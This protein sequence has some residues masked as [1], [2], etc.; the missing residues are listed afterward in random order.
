MP[1]THVNH[2]GIETSQGVHFPMT[3]GYK[4]LH[5]FVTVDALLGKDKPSVGVSYLDRFAPN[6]DVFEFIASEKYRLNQ[7]TPPKITITL[8]DVLSVALR[9]NSRMTGS[10]A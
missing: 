7:S 2:P 5:V 1:L 9:R 8:E 10:L 6:R 4:I 3:N